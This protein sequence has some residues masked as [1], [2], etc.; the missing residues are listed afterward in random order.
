MQHPF[1]DTKNSRSAKFTFANGDLMIFQAFFKD[2]L[3]TVFRKIDQF[4][5]KRCQKKRKGVSYKLLQ[6]F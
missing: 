3:T 4:G 2:S 6:Y 5:D 1:E